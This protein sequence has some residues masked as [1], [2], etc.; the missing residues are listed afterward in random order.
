MKKKII[1]VSTIVRIVSPALHW[2]GGAAA[3]NKKAKY[4]VSKLTGNATYP[5]AL[6]PA[7]TPLSKLVADIAA[8]DAALLK[9]SGRGK[10]TASAAKAAE[11]VVKDDLTAIETMV[12][13]VMQGDVANA[14]SNCAS[15]GFDVRVTVLHG[16]RKD[17]AQSVVEGEVELEGSGAGHHQWQQSP[18]EGETII[19]LDPTSG[20]KK[21]VT[22]LTSNI[23]LW[24]RN[25]TVLTKGQYGEWSAWIK[26]RVK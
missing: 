20:G 24:F 19:N 23:I 9:A 1:H 14:E 18:D 22:G 17:S 15:A 5:A 12:K 4:I 10:G 3:K 21:T 2:K 16:K 8:W 26:I 13:L 7:S 11:K 6:Y 25:R